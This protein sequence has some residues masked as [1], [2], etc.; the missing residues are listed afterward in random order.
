MM[1]MVGGVT[2]AALDTVT[3]FVC[4]ELMPEDE[5]LSL[6]V[7]AAYRSIAVLGMGLSGVAICW[8]RRGD[9]DPQSGLLL[10]ITSGGLLG[11]FVSPTFLIYICVILAVTIDRGAK[12]T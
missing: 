4:K 10:C 5:Y 1:F 8:R 7:M 11:L 9:E 2:G 12:Q 6:V 3:Y